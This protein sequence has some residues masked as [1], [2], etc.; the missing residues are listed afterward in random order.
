MSVTTMTFTHGSALDTGLARLATSAAAVLRS[1]ATVF[2]VSATRREPRTAAELLAWAEQYE[3]TQPSY[4]ADLR[5]AAQIH[6]G[7]GD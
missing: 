1:V 2:D 4:A 6:L 7:R 3:S 5:A